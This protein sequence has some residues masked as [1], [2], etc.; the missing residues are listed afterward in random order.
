MAKTSST[1]LYRVKLDK[2]VTLS[3]PTLY[4][5]HYLCISIIIHWFYIGITFT[6]GSKVYRVLATLDH[7]TFC[8]GAPA[9]LGSSLSSLPVHPYAASLSEPNFSF[10]RGS[11]GRIDDQLMMADLPL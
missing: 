1:H 8:I 5:P 10:F 2:T 7:A 11:V 9:Q 4:I 3:A 6:L